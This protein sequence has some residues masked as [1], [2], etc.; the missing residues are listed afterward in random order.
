M[1]TSCLLVVKRVFELIGNMSVTI[2]KY[3]GCKPDI[4]YNVMSKTRGPLL[5]AGCMKGECSTFTRSGLSR[6]RCELSDKI[7]S[8]YF[9]KLSFLTSLPPC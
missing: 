2:F 8:L 3:G 4:N 7:I 9:A 6:E 1:N 5:T